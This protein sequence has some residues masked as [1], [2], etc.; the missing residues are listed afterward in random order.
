MLKPPS[1]VI[2]VDLFPEILSGLLDLLRDLD[3]SEWGRPTICEGWSVKDV[4]LHLLGIEI[5]NLSTRRDKHSSGVTVDHWEELVRFINDWNQDWVR[6][7]RRISSQLLI[8]LLEL[9]GNQ[10]CEFFRSLDPYALGNPIS[11]VGPNP[12]PAWL[13]L[14][15][16]YTERWHHQQHIR[17]AVGRSGLK[18]P[19]Y[20]APALETFAWALPQTFHQIWAPENATIALTIHGESGGQWSIRREGK[21][22]KFY[23][24]SDGHAISEVVLLEDVAWR[25]FTRGMSKSQARE[26][27]TL[28]GVEVLGLQLLG[29]VSIIA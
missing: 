13:D 7:A 6:V 8:D 22:W 27:A 21:S 26:S 29:M 11:W 20:F 9:T 23:E 28:L 1:P 19:R 10:M 3:E 16:E 24:G 17:D 14:A 12:A 18:E 25:L 5:G 2:V 4:A 15:R